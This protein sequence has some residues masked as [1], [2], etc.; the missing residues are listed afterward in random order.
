MPIR[1]RSDFKQAL[2]TLRQL[3]DQE[4][5][6]HQQRWTQSY[7]STWWNWQESWWHS[8][9]EHHHEDVPAPIDTTKTYPAPLDQGKPDREVIRSLIR[10]MILRINL[11]QYCTGCSQL[12][13]YSNHS[14]D[15]GCTIMDDC[16]TKASD[17]FPLRRKSR[18]STLQPY[19]LNAQRVRATNK[20]RACAKTRGQERRPHKEFTT[21]GIVHLISNKY[22]L[23]SVTADGSLLSPTGGVNTIPPIQQSHT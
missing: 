17:V 8:S 6:A 23:N 11:M 20:R 12:R 9:Y 10:G 7:S 16:M 3:K 18:I 4:D 14:Q 5:A 21:A 22:R 1:H 15:T 19:G 13:P 2:S